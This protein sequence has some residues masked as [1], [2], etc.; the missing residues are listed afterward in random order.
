MI[1]TILIP[2][3]T[4]AKTGLALE[5]ATAIARAAAWPQ[6]PPPSRPAKGR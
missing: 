2:F 6:W 4:S 1:Q 3:D 5:Y